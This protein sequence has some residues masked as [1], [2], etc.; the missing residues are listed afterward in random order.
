VHT[1]IFIGR[2]LTTAFTFCK[3]GNQR[4]EVLLLAWETLFPNE[5]FLPHISQLFDILLMAPF[6][7]V[8]QFKHFAQKGKGVF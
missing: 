5:G 1:D 7:K 2:P 8:A 6:L 3:L 4:R